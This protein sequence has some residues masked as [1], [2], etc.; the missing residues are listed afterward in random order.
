MELSLPNAPL[1]VEGDPVRLTQI[2]AN[3]LDNAAKYTP[4]GGQIAVDAR[5]GAGEA[6]VTIRDN[7]PGIAPDALEHVFEMFTRG[8][9]P[10]DRAQ[11]GLGIGLALARRLAVMHGGSLEARSEG[12]SH[13]SAFTLRLPASAA[14]VGERPAAPAAAAD[15]GHQRILVVD[16]NFDAGDSLA[17]VLRQMGADTRV[18]RDGP[19]AIQ[20]F[21]AYA[22]SVVLLDIGMPGMDGYQVARILRDRFPQRRAALVAL[23]GWGQEKA[24][25]LAREAGFDHHLVKPTEIAALRELLASL[26]D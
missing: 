3:L 11:G 16:D 13:G 26:Q 23:T 7:G 8:S 10:A 17:E 12:K 24:R 25:A 15:L 18:A 20:A 9:A 5:R 1:W 22:P 21:E 6:V 19:E 2:L 14:A 4:D